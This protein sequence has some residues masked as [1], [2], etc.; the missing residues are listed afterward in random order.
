MAGTLDVYD[1]GAYEKD[2]NE[3]ASRLHRHWTSFILISAVMMVTTSYVSDLD[4]M[5]GAG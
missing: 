4:I 2:V 3:T 5:L 1:L